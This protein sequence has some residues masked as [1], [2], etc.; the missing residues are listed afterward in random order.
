MK[1]ATCST[2]DFI[3]ESLAIYKETGDIIVH[4]C[5]DGKDVLPLPCETFEEFHNRIHNMMQDKLIELH[6]KYGIE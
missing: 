4:Q 1:P 6:N 2:S 5:N 3:K